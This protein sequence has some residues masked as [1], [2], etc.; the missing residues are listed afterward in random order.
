MRS[1][2]KISAYVEMVCTQ[3]RFKRAHERVARELEHHVIDTQD[4]Y[5]AEGLSEA[6]A[7]EKA[8]AD[9]GDP[10]VIGLEFD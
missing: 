5:I 1:P 2:E 4:A 7:A 6:S 10:A 8:I 3:I 9:T